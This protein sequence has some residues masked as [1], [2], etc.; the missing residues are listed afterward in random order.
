MSR[1]TIRRALEGLEG[2]GLVE[3]TAGRGTIVVQP[4]DAIKS[5]T[6]TGYIDDVVLLNRH[7]VLDDEFR[8]LPAGIP[9]LIRMPENERVRCIRTVN[10][11]GELPLSF[12]HFYFPPATE[13]FIKV[14]D[15]YGTVPPIKVVEA[16]S[17]LTVAFAE[18]IV[19]A[20]S[21]SEEV[22][23]RL[24]LATTTPVLRATRAYFTADRQCL[25]VAYVHY[26]PDRYRY[27]ATLLPRV[28]PIR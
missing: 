18:Q 14:D 24:D 1:I 21:A 13:A 23:Q 12:S 11:A 7:H 3:R 22:A 15:F 17:G 9:A 28:L 8:T 6:L 25:E 4:E 16:N 26:H 5:I 10:H 27:R 20:V 2:R 19:D